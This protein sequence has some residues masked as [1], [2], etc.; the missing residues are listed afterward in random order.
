[1]EVDETKDGNVEDSEILQEIEF[2]VGGLFFQCP[3]L[4]IT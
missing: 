2:T 1:M 4:V 3:I